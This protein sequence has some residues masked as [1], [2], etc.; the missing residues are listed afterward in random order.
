MFPITTAIDAIRTATP[1]DCRLLM[2][3]LAERIVAD[4]PA[5]PA[6]LLANPAGQTVG[7][8]FPINLDPGRPPV[9]TPEDEVELQR[10]IATID[11]SYTTEE[12]KGFIRQG[13][14]T[15]VPKS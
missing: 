7:Y 15:A 5:A 1:A 4:S 8:F 13:R 6:V 2:A 3:A 9:M 12:M 10:R 11:N 14:P